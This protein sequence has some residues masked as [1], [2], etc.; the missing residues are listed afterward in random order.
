MIGLGTGFLLE[1]LDDT[2]KTSEDV[3]KQLGLVTLGKIG[4]FSNAENKVVVISDPRSP[5]GE[6]FRVLASNIRFATLDQPARI[7]LVTSPSP[8]DGKSAVLAN[9]A[10]TMARSETNVIALDA[11]LRLPRQHKLF[12]LDPGSGLTGALMAKSLNG[13]LRNGD[14][15]GLKILTSGELPGNPTEVLNS[16]LMRKMVI[17][18]SQQTDLLLIDGPPVLPFAD[19]SILASQSDGVILVLRANITR[20]R[21][22]KDTLQSLQQAGARILGVVL[23]DVSARADGYYRY[24]YYDKARSKRDTEKW[25][26][27]RNNQPGKDSAKRL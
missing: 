10:V 22:A 11:D 20:S 24:H 21:A 27:W 9:L 7:L 5:V 16:S 14:V 23:N 4:S 26:F 3:S 6:D 12:G 19:A 15:S 13:R 1:Y 25:M 2:I 18:L 8:R 17:E